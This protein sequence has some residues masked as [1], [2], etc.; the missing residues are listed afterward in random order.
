[1]PD[2]AQYAQLGTT[3][4]LGLALVWALVQVVKMKRNGHGNGE[5]KELKDKV[6]LIEGNHLSEVGAKLDE[7][8]RQGQEAD[9]K[10][11]RMIEKLIE[12]KK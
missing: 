2:F 6:D 11:D 8:I 4:I 3:F 5:L 7:L 1:M 10:H 9:R 12:L